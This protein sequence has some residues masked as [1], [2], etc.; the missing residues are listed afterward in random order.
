MLSLM[1]VM[2]FKFLQLHTFTTY[3]EMIDY[4][5]HKGDLWNITLLVS[6]FNKMYHTLTCAYTCTYMQNGGHQP[7]AI[8]PTNITHN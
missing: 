8:N 1:A 5:K 4:S 7:I 2:L 3:L 6:I